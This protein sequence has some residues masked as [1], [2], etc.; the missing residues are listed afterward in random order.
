MRATELVLAAIML[1]TSGAV[2]AGQGCMYE[3]EIANHINTAFDIENG[4]FTENAY[5][6]L[7]GALEMVDENLEDVQAD[8]AHL[9]TIQMIKSNVL[10]NLACLE[11]LQNNTEEAF[12]WLEKAIDTGFNDREWMES[13]AD[14]TGLHEDP[15]FDGLLMKIGTT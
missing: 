7:T 1:L 4:T 3:H 10:Y 6:I 14:L 2:F 5:A 8:P 15:R 12:M 9:E 13:D 11:A